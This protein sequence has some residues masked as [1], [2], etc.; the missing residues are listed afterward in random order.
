M[1]MPMDTAP[2]DRSLVLAWREDWEVPGWVQWRENS[3][4]ETTFWNDAFEHDAYENE[5]N[6][7]THWWYVAE[8]PVP[9]KY[10]KLACAHY[11]IGFTNVDTGATG[12]LCGICNA[13][14]AV[15]IER[16]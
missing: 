12:T 9:C 8:P 1:W 2:K 5:D 10:Y 11:P 6:P 4:T 16:E 3:R 13:V 15:N 7:P 14:L